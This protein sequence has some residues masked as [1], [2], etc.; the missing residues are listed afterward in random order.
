MAKFEVEISRDVCMVKTFEIEAEDADKAKKLA[1]TAAYD[2]DWT[3][4]SGAVEYSVLSVD[5]MELP[6]QKPRG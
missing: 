6:T 4:C 5:E 1:E 2:T 3:G